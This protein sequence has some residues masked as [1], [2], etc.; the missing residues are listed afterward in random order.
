MGADKYLPV[1]IKSLLFLIAFTPLVTSDSLFFYPFVF[2]KTLFYRGVI[3]TALLLFLVYLTVN[4]YKNRSFP[5]FT[6]AKNPLFVFVCLFF[7]SA[8]ASSFFAENSYRAFFGY[9]ERGEGF[10]GIIHYFIFLV[11]AVLLFQKRDWLIFFKLSLAVGATV[12][13]YAWLQYFRITK[14]P[15]ALGADA[16]PG[17]FTGNPAYLASYLILLFAMAALV[18]WNSAPRSFWRYF[19]AAFSVFS[20]L[21]IFIT[22]V[23]GAILGIAAG[24][25]FLCL[26]FIFSR[27][28]EFPGKSKLRKVFAA[29]LIFLV[30][31]SFVFWMTKGAAF[32]LKLP[33]FS[34][35]TSVSLQN[36][37][38]VTRL[39]SL[40]ISWE[41]FK[42]RPLLGWGMDNFN[43]AYNKHYDPAHSLY[44]ED[45][46]DR[47]HNRIADIAVMQGIFGL[48]AYFGMF[49][50]AFYLLFKKRREFVFM[51]P[52]LGSVFIA[53]FVNNLF[54][55]DQITSYIPLFAVFGFMASWD[56]PA[57]AKRER[58]LEFKYGLVFMFASFAAAVSIL[59]SL[60]FW[61][62]IPVYQIREFRGAMALKVG[63]KILAASDRFLL[64]YNYIQSEL[65]QR[66][67]EI[68][69]N[70]SLIANKKFTSLT[71]KGLLAL[72]EVTVK[73]PYEPRLLSALIESY[74]ERAKEDP[75]VFHKSEGFARKAVELSPRRQGL[76]YLLAF[77]LA[78]EEK[79]DES[80]ALAK[81]TLA[82]SPDSAKAHY[83]LAIAFALAADSNKYKGTARQ[84]EYR[85]E[86]L[87]ELDAAFDLGSR[88][89]GSLE[90]FLGVAAPYERNSISD[91]QFFLFLE[92]D[93]K[94]M[95]I[96]YRT[97]GLPDRMA[98]T[99]EVLSAYYENKDYRYDA[100]IVYRALRDKDGVIRHAKAL[101]AMDPSLANDMDAIID[102]AEKGNWEILDTL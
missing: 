97:M 63:E 66:L 83:N 5:A 23:R 2:G 75:S 38:V 78:G 90:P 29:L 20:L 94:N 13:F 27:G 80:L 47:A 82:L 102:L 31:L 77:T 96:L 21:T 81:Q 7:L 12:S 98:K 61:N 91:S 86:A 48:L 43:V 36:P 22:S 87:K 33:G 10:Y 76:L 57:D 19:S 32:W 28:L 73:E 17:S 101:K 34:R 100:I 79:F 92:S 74:N 69:Y 56:V 42:E 1:S 99:L 46:F 50:S 54:L 18:F 35:F 39:I 41:A 68:F 85:A 55:F 49:L 58:L 11:I 44:A 16:Q 88:R 64:P 84:T 6:F 95:V 65:R 62:Y 25:L 71:D 67:V 30:A 45:W 53:H 3:E 52:I 8:A 60:Y 4:F 59:Y 37:S 24:F 40:K 93:L 89:I 51:A 72:E 70:S 26:Y 15:F 14:F 9:M